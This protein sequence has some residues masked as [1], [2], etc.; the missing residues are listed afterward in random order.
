MNIQIYIYIY[1]YIYTRKDHICSLLGDRNL[2]QQGYFV[3]FWQDKDKTTTRQPQDNH[4]ANHKIKTRQPRD[5]RQDK[6][7][8]NHKTKQNNHKIGQDKT[9]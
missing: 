9:K 3:L 6:D 5:K 7:K 2:L 4:K 8:T 1:I